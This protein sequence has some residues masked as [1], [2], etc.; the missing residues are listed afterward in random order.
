MPSVKI[1]GNTLK[2]ISNLYAR[3]DKPSARTYRDTERPGLV[4]NVGPRGASWKI[5]TNNL[6][7][8]IAP[9]HRFGTKDIETLRLFVAD[10]L[11]AHRAGQKIKT[12]IDA[13][14]AS[15]DIDTAKAHHEVSIGNS[16]LWEDARD[17]YMTWAFTEYADDTAAGYKSALG[18]SARSSYVTEFT[19]ISGK[20]IHS[21][22]FLDLSAVIENFVNRG[23]A[24]AALGKSNGR[25]QTNLTIYALKSAFKYFAQNPSKFGLAGDP[26][27]ELRTVRGVEKKD[28]K[29]K[30]Y[31]EKNSSKKNRSMTSIEIGAFVHGLASVEN[32]IARMILFLQALTGQR[33]LD[34]AAALKEGFVEHEVYGLVWRLEDK[35][36]SWR[37]LPLGPVAAG[38]V[39]Q[40]LEDFAKYPSTFLFPKAKPRKRTDDRNGHMHKRTA[41]GK[42]FE[43]R[44]E[45]GPLHG[46]T[47]DPATHDLRKAFTSVMAPRMSRFKDENGEPLDRGDTKIITHRNEGRDETATAVYDKNEYLDLKYAILCNWEEY[48]MRCYSDYVVK[49]NSQQPALAA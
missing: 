44:L 11:L 33:I 27:V 23:K 48:V 35:T 26:S 13:F 49:L 2:S 12:M 40:S 31:Q 18:A 36:R 22:T 24:S 3:E 46:S 10:A 5:A 8:V 6:N 42:M 34:T 16:M 25:R 45:G 15:K 41:Q 9:F 38:V 43:M 7:A 17:D 19:P 39:R 21:I 4:I 1:D 29:D 14:V 47:I 20:P 30:A 32:E 37:A 28:R